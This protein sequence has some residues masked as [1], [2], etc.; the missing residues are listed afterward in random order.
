MQVPFLDLKTQYKNIKAEIDRAILDVVEENWFVLGP[1]VKSFEEKFASYLGVKHVISTNSGTSALAIL[2]MALQEKYGWEKGKWEAI[3]PANTFIATAESVILAGGKVVLA[4]IHEDT[5]NI[6]SGSIETGITAN[7][8][9]V[10]PVHLYGQ[11]ADME[12][13]A[14]IAGKYGLM[15]VEDCAQAHGAKYY[16]EKVGKFGIGSEF[17]FYPG[18]NLGAYGDGG[19]VAS[20]SDE[21]ADWI[22][23]FRDHGSR[24]KYI[25]EFIGT[26]ERLDT[27]QAEVLNIK[28]KY[29]DQWNAARRKNAELYFKY[30]QDVEEIILPRVPHW[31]EPVWHLFVIRAKNREQLADHL[32]TADIGYGYHYKQPLHF[33]PALKDLDK[34]KGDFPVTEKVMKEIVSLPMYAELSEAQIKYVADSI[35]KFYSLK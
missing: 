19:A 2:L 21:L 14:Q 26:T 10:I 16:G 20:N 3:L 9:V 27:I 29:L 17:S 34:K 28:L 11:P 33:M 5:Y 35:K 23:M 18:K 32:A 7:T 8:K 25:H 22:R 13:V 24:E 15:I 12:P 31:A 6:D 1:R 4:D 30:L